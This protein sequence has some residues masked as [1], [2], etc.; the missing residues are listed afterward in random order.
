[1]VLVLEVLLLLV[2]WLVGNLRTATY[3]PERLLFEALHF[4]RIGAAA[5][6]QLQVFADRVIE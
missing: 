2:E 4:V 6:L 5:P 1:M 3:R